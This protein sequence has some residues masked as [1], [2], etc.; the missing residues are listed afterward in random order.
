MHF[1]IIF[2]IQRAD[3]VC[4]MKDLGSVYRQTS[5]GTEP[6]ALCSTYNLL[7]NHLSRQSIPV[8]FRI[9][10]NLVQLTRSNAFCQ[11]MK[12]AHNS[13]YVSQVCSQH[14]NCIPSSFSSSKSKL[15]FSKCILN[16]PFNPSS[17][18]PCYYLCCMCDG[19]CIL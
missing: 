10:I 4:H 19:R 11:S 2:P 1:L 15:I 9:C 16:F 17:I 6:T 3:K 5:T 14:P 12:Q 7:I 13:S 8:P 18:F